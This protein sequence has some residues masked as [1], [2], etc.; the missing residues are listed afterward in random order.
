MPWKSAPPDV[1]ALDF[2]ASRGAL[3]GREKMR[4]CEKQV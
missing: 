1:A 2:I 3:R 4:T